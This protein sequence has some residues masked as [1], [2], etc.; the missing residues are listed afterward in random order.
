MNET[1]N[2]TMNKHDPAM[3]QS[4]S[5]FLSIDDDSGVF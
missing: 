4:S 5:P 2:T 1:K 3:G